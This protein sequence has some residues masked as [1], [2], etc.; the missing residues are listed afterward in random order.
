MALVGVVALLAITGIASAATK[1]F[2]VKMS[3]GQEA[4]RHSGGSGEATLKLNA[5]TG[6]VCWAFTHLKGVRNPQAA[7]IHKG[8][9]GVAGPIVVPLGGAFKARGCTKA[10]K[11]TV[12]AI[13]RRPGGYYVNIHTT[14]FP[15]GAIR[16]QL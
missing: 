6:R 4:P 8:K 7:H 2:T 5:G 10:S 1:T 16:G 9:K 3:G 13:V 12:K 14:R 11:A 15:A